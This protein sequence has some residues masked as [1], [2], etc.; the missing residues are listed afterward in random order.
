MLHVII[1]STL[2]QL[3]HEGTTLMPKLIRKLLDNSATAL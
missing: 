3:K 2:D 1:I